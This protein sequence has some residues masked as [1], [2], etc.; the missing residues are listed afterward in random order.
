LLHNSRALTGDIAFAL[1]ELIFKFA[2]TAASY[3][4]FRFEV[5]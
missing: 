2:D 5:S 3:A 1:L 4:V